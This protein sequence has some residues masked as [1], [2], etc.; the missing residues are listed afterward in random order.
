[1]QLFLIFPLFFSH[2]LFNSSI[3]HYTLNIQ[4]STT[5]V[6]LLDGKTDEWPEEKFETDKV[7]RIR[8]AADN[9]QQTLFIA[10]IVSDYSMQKRIM[11]GLNLYVDTKG[12]KKEHQGVE[13]PTAGNPGYMKLFGFGE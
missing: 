8:Y 4:D 13:F 10:L 9:D 12:K 5:I 2:F 11:Q 3:T 6:H 7:T 1:M